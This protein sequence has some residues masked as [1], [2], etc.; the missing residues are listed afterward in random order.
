M[1]NLIDERSGMKIDFMIKKDS[2]YRKLEFERKQFTE[3]FGHKV[4]VV[5]VDDLIISKLI[6]IQ[7]VQSGRQVEDIQALL[8]NQNIDLKYIRKW[9]NELGLTT[10]DLIK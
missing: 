7:E 8:T 1:F 6:W 3:L 9:I 10:F 5:S 4:W 2:P